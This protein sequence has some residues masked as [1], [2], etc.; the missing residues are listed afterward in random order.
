[1]SN[2][3]KV[4][5]IVGILLVLVGLGGGVAMTVFGMVRTFNQ[6]L[7][8][9]LA[10]PNELAAG[11]STSLMATAVGVAV[12]LVGLVL[13]VVGIVLGVRERGQQRSSVPT[14]GP[15]VGA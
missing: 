10:K 5:L 3:A 9:E 6:V 14:D 1:M 15:P 4:L 11:I 13:V 2:R 12:G 7:T 8:P